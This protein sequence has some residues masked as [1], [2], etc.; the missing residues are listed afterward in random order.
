MADIQL[1]LEAER[2]GILPADK[3]GLLQEARNRGLIP[4]LDQP[5]TVTPTP[6]QT[7]TIVDQI[8][9]YGGP[10]PA[11]TAPVRTK[12]FT[13]GQKI[14]GAIETVPALVTGAVTAPI[15]EGAK[16]Y[17]ALTSGKFGTQAGIKA[18]EKTGR[19]VQEQFFQPRTQAGQEYVGNIGNALASTGLQGVPMNVL[20]DLQ[21]GMTPAVR[22]VTDVTGSKVAQRA[23]R[24]A[25]EASNKDY[26]RA[27]KIDAGKAARELG[28]FVNP[29]EVNPTLGTNLAVGAA[30][31]SN[32]SIKNA[33][34]NNVKLSEIARDDLGLPKNTPLDSKA[35]DKALAI[36]DAPYQAVEKIPVMQA[37]DDVLAQINGLKLDPRSTNNPEKVARINASVDRTLEQVVDGL[38]GKNVVSQIRDFRKDANQTFKNPNA[39]GIDISVAESQIGIANALE[40]LI[41]SNIK[42]PTALD[43]LRAART[44]KAKVYDWERATSVAT[45]QVDPTQLVKMIEKGQ[46]LSGKLAQVAE[47]AGNFPKD[48]DLSRNYMREAF[49]YLRRGG[50]GGTI[51]L[52]FGGPLGAAIGA[53][54]TSL[55]GEAAARILA[56]PGVQNRLATPLDRRIPLPEEINIPRSQNALIPVG[57][58][59]LDASGQP[60]ARLRIIDYDVNGN[61]IYA[62]ARGDRAPGAPG[63]PDFTMQSEPIFGNRPTVFESQRG[64]PNEVP[65]QVYDAQR[66]A[67]LAQEFRAKD[68]RLPARGGTAFELDPVTGKLVPVDTTLRGATPDIQIIESTGKTLESAIAKMSGQMVPETTG[69]VYKTQ[70]ISPKTG[71]QPYTRI[72]KKEGETTFD[73]QSQAFNMT[74]EEK[75]AFNKARV[76][77][78]EVVPGMKTLTDKA[79]A[80]R[81][82]DRE[83]VQQAVTKAKEKAQMLDDIIARSDN[84]RTRQ[85]AMMKREVLQD[86]LETL[87]EQ[88]RKAR[89]VKTGGQGP[90]T[91]AFQQNMLRP[92]DGEIQNALVK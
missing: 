78:A 77:L 42:D 18:G 33:K 21:R 13:L 29:A 26:E 91:R 32:V 81:L 37:S 56:R 53:G 27:S 19:R 76:D 66:R 54:I 9:G 34:V 17:G 11:A 24:L 57:P 48:F 69:T 28:L 1:F 74:A 40:N 16:I 38:S 82:M 64:L 55:G 15:V 84:E 67:E 65:R 63:T 41:E 35:W 22:A 72:T 25:Q 44:G 87:E 45:K 59:V 39:T 14:M 20:A 85:D 46:P 60:A 80:G 6:R 10:V 2:R 49:Q 68:E 73:R 4:Q 51:G 52:A 12:N 88:F 50:V 47:V 43:A 75:I 89:P 92:D 58:E 31:K 8:P 79:L 61:P 62:P 36:H 70:T 30:G 5:I 90:K 3:L 83:W 71:A 7:G 86:T 23:E